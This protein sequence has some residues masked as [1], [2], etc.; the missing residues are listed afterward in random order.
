[1]TNPVLPLRFPGNSPSY[2]ESLSSSLSAH[3]PPLSCAVPGSPGFRARNLKIRMRK[4][5]CFKYI[6][7]PRSAEK[8]KEGSRLFE[9]R[10]GNEFAKRPLFFRSQLTNREG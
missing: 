8:E 10:W 3:T 6:F 4:R 2:L 1:M 9:E 5:I 7:S